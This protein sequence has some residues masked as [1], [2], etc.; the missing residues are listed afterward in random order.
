M[1]KFPRAVRALPLM[2]TCRSYTAKRKQYPRLRS[3][4]RRRNAC[5]KACPITPGNA[6]RRTLKIFLKRVATRRRLADPH[7]VHVGGRA[8]NDAPWEERLGGTAASLT[9]LFVGRRQH[10]RRH[11]GRG[12]CGFRGSG[13]PVAPLG[14]LTLS[15]LASAATVSD[16]LPDG[17]VKTYPLSAPRPPFA[18]R[19]RAGGPSDCGTAP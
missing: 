17:E 14:P 4:W 2:Y 16:G 11:R 9:P 7:A 3:P 13:A 19:D 8:S 18:R 1:S 5:P 12:L 15:P 10:G 6:C